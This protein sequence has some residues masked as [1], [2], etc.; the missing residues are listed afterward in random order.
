MEEFNVNIL[1]NFIQF[2]KTEI[3]NVNLFAGMER[4]DKVNESMEILN[5]ELL[6]YKRADN[7][8]IQNT[9]NGKYVLYNENTIIGSSNLLFVILIEMSNLQKENPGKKYKIK[10][11]A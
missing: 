11:R 7:K 6:K 10:F 8:I 9:E 5:N 4:T 3:K 2:Y 1:N